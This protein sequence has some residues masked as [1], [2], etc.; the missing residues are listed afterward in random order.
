MKVTRKACYNADCG[1]A[2]PEFLIELVR[3]GGE[4]ICIS[5]KFPSEADDSDL[6]TT[7]GERLFQINW[8]FC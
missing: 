3:L 2:P 5:T 8:L 4:G 6:E 1:L 7:F